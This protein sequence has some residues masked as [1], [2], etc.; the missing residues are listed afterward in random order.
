MNERA[1]RQLL[2]SL[3]A[4]LER[5]GEALAVPEDRPLA[6]DGTIQRFEFTFELFW[7]AVR[8][9][10]AGQGVEANSPRAVLQQA[11]RLGWLDDEERCLKLLEDRNLT[12]HTY[13]EGL[14]REIYRR[15]PLHHAAMREVVQKLRTT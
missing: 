5:L 4:S 11:D 7:T 6:V 9:L 1:L 12:S 14:A 8:C 15:I 2:D 10:R 13:R 3:N